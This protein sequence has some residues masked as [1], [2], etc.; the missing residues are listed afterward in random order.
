MSK[1]IRF[2]MPEKKS[3]LHGEDKQ[4]HE[5]VILPFLGVRYSREGSE[6]SNTSIFECSGQKPRRSGPRR[7]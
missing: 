2:V 5:T 7:G 6:Q 3:P 1:I 4:R